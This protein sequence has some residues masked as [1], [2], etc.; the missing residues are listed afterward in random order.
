MRCAF[1]E[2]GVNLRR[3]YDELLA[4]VRRAPVELVVEGEPVVV[5]YQL[6]VYN[7]LGLLYD[8]SLAPFLAD[9]LQM[10]WAASGQRTVRRA[11]R[12]RAQRPRP[13][14]RRPPRD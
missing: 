3:K 9:F 5:N 7:T 4:R 12:G 14:A 10:T 2:P 6:L 8:A 11:A 1:R 13:C